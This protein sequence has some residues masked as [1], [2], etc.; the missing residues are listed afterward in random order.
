MLHY[1]DCLMLQPTYTNAECTM[2]VLRVQKRMVYFVFEH[3]FTTTGSIFLTIF[4]DH[5]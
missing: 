3:N 5:Y 4:S 2:Y 1:F